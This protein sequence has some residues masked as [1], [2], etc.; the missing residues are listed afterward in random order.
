MAGTISLEPLEAEFADVDAHQHS[1]DGVDGEYLGGAGSDSAKPLPHVILPS[2]KVTISQCAAEIFNLVAPTRSMFIRGGVV[3]IIDR[4]DRGGYV[5]EVLRPSA[6]RSR[7]EKH[8]RLFAWRVGYKGKEV[9]Q[10]TI[11]PEETAR[12]IIESQEARDL[13]PK[14][15]GL[16]NCPFLKAA[17]GKL[18][19]SG[20]GY[21][22]DTGVLVT[23]GKKPPDVPFNEAVV[24]LAKLVSEFDFQCPGDRS[25]AI[26]SFITPALKTGGLIQG[27]VPAD[28]AEADQS[29][30]GKTYRQKLVAAVYNESVSIVSQKIGGVGSVDESLSARLVEGRPF[31]QFDNFRGRVDSGHLEAFLTAEGS[32]PARVPY[33]GEVQIDPD[34][35]FIFLSSNGVETTRDMANRSSIIR[36][37][38]RQRFIY[39]DFPEGDLLSHIRVNQPY[40]LACVFAV[41]Q[42]WYYRGQP[43]S[44]ELRHDFRDWC[45]TLDWIVQ[46]LFKTAPLMEG[47]RGAQ[48][49]VS[50]PGLTFVRNLCLA[51]EAEDS[52]ETPLIASQLY[53]IAEIAGVEVPGLRVADED[54]GRKIIGSIMAKVFSDGDTVELDGFRA[55]KEES[56]RDREDTTAG[57]SYR[58]KSYVFTKL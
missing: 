18:S 3:T 6:A 29:Q 1:D 16:I 41:I 56:I 32:F 21:D 31:I 44:R 2:G 46:N 17:H 54:R 40:Y 5:L 37:R 35:F 58:V 27:K 36:I 50:N 25:R 4:N 51:L 22:E 26:A 57:G 23:G 49:R 24:A 14:I 11:C 20:V 47:H 48:E 38:K 39:S 52:L 28:V 15:S 7:F 55:V 10:P 30:S 8:G 42:E 9:L 12:A 13:L 19:V 43:R 33:R 34:R 53:D 45:L